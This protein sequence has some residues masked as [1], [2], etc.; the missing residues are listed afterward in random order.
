MKIVNLLAHAVSSATMILI[1]PKQFLKIILRVLLG[2]KSSGN[3]LVT[4]CVVICNCILA[5]IT[6]TIKCI[7]YVF[8]SEGFTDFDA[9]LINLSQLAA[10]IM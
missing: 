4:C 5:N 10:I 2:D 6:E 1:N 7:S 9:I 8:I 3:V